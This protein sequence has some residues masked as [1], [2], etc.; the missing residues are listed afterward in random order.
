MSLHQFVV[1]IPG[2]DL[3]LTGYNAGNPPES[4]FGKLSDAIIYSTLPAAQAAAAAI[5]H[6]TVGST[7]P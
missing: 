4:I 6:G 1:T 5:G 3:F 7:K 2:T